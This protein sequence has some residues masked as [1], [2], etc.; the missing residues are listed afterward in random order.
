MGGKKEA[1]LPVF[2]WVISRAE[3]MKT[4]MIASVRR[5]ARLPP[6]TKDSD[7]PS[8]FLT[9]DA[10]TPRQITSGSNQ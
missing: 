9:N 3:M 1:I 7:I 8:H 10:E 6:M 4:R 2:K 5:A